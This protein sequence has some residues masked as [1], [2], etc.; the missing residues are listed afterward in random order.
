MNS[1]RDVGDVVSD[2]QGKH[3]Q[4]FFKKNYQVN[5]MLGV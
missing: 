2:S 3:S 4:D 1:F 5:Y